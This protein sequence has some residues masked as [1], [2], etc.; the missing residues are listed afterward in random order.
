MSACRGGPMNLEEFWCDVIKQNRETL[1][2][3]FHEDAIIRWPCT[4]EQF[5]VDEYVRV[6]CDYPGNWNGEIARIE[7][8]GSSVIL[9]GRV[10]S[11][12]K[13]ESFHVVSLIALRDDKICEME[14]YWADDGDAPD[15][16]RKLHIGKPI[17]R[18]P[19]TE[20]TL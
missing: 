7:E 9:V 18:F 3:Y 11:A 12:D 13:S 14:E 17:D 19:M 4:N 15:W 16:R 10:F 5:T 20:K 6:N 2:S 8:T 1:P